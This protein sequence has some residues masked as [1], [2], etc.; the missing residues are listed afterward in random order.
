MP[1]LESKM[2]GN[3]IIFHIEIESNEKNRNWCVV[4]CSRSN[5]AGGFTIPTIASILEYPYKVDTFCGKESQ[6]IKKEYMMP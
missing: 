2:E 5:Y 6:T 1:K 4:V 3:R